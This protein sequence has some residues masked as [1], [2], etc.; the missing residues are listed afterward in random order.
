MSITTKSAGPIGFHLPGPT[1]RLRARAEP[2]GPTGGLVGGRGGRLDGVVELTIV[3]I[4]V[5][6]PP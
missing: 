6:R 2:S 3:E 5:Q 4:S 1:L